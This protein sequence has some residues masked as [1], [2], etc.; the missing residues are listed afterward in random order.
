LNE[1]GWKNSKHHAQW[2]ATLNTYAGPIRETLV[3]TFVHFLADS[4][5]YKFLILHV[6]GRGRQS[7]K[8]GRDPLEENL[9]EV[10]SA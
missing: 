4:L 6:S 9:G 5:T 3:A 1:G 8:R 10:R 2:V 7:K